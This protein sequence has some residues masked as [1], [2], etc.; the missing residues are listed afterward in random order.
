MKVGI[1]STQIPIISL[2]SVN[3]YKIENV[4]SIVSGHGEYEI[5]QSDHKH[6]KTYFYIDTGVLIMV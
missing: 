1:G 3:F 5:T 4:E 2:H 6:A